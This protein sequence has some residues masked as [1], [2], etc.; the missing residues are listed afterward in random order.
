MPVC[1]RIS[2]LIIIREP[3]RDSGATSHVAHTDAVTDWRLTDHSPNVAL[4]LGHQYTVAVHAQARRVQNPNHPM[5]RIPD[6]YLLVGAL[7]NVLR[8]AEMARNTI[9]S[10]RA[11]AEIQRAIGIFLSQVVIKPTKDRGAALVLARDVLE[12]FD[13]Y[14]CGIGRRQGQAAKH[15]PGTSEED[16]AQNYRIDFE[17]PADRPQL[18]V[19]P[20]RPAEPLVVIDLVTTAPIAA[21]QLVDSI[22]A[23]LVHDQLRTACE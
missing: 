16:L 1:A 20:L 23:A 15:N 22:R 6:V 3:S 21:R 5:E 10:R 14:M 4:L 11:K 13:K 7:H 19:G 2:A 8:A 17:P 9:P 18:R 12:H